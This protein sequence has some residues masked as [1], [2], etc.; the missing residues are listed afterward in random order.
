MISG[1]NGLPYMNV[2]VVSISSVTC[3]L[4]LLAHVVDAAVQPVK[5]TD[6]AGDGFLAE[7]HAVLEVQGEFL[8]AA[9]LQCNQETLGIFT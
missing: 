7:L 3:S 2:S 5:D 9:V 8:L 4:D 1:V 6:E